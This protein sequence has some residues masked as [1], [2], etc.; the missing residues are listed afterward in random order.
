[1][2]VLFYQGSSRP[3]EVPSI[4]NCYQKISTEFCR[5]Y[6]QYWDNNFPLIGNLFANN[7]K[8]TFLDKQIGNINQLIDCVS[9]E[10]I[11]K[12]EHNSIYGISQPLDDNT[13]LINTYGYISFNRAPYCRK[14]T[15]T[16]VIKRDIY[17][18]WY[19]IN[20]MF[21]IIPDTVF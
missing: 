21:R 6:Y 9:N 4:W 17:E 19:I 7:I 18:N 10:G 13:I 2:D 20:I 1:M 15:D 8:I 5:Q 3:P 16:I 12:F 11:W 14:F